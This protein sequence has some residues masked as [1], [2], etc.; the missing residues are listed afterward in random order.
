M[1]GNTVIAVSLVGNVVLTFA[2][3]GLA[4]VARR[5]NAEIIRRDRER[6]EIA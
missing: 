6:W 1:R 2:A 4:F 3:V 5:L